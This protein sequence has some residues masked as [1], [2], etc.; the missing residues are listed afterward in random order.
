VNV[1]VHGFG[2]ALGAN[3]AD[4]GDA[5]LW[6]PRPRSTLLGGTAKGGDLSPP[7]LVAD[8]PLDYFFLVAFFGEAFFAFFTGL[9]PPL[10]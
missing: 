4:G 7:L 5:P 10:G 8:G 2:T 1:N 3:G 9:I 6:G